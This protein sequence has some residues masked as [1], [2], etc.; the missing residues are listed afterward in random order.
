MKKLDKEKLVDKILDMIILSSV[1][2]PKKPG[3]LIK[4]HFIN[5]GID[6]SELKP[7]DFN[8]RIK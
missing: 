6:L 1:A 5:K 3:D 7:E 2:H 8:R 4:K